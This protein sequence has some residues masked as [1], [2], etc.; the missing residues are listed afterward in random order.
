VILAV[1]TRILLV[2]VIVAAVFT[3]IVVAAGVAM[4]AGLDSL[5]RRRLAAHDVALEARSRG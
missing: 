4:F 2:A 3:L 1:T 5:A